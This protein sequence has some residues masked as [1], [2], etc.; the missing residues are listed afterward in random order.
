MANTTTKTKKMPDSS[1]LARFRLLREVGNYSGI[2]KLAKA[3]LN[4]PSLPADDKAGIS[5]ILMATE[6]EPLVFWIGLGS[7]AFA[8]VLA[9]WLTH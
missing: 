4:D 3:S 2:R 1:L 9:Y 6:P 7:V 8:T 5:Q